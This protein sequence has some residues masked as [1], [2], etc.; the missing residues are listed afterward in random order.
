MTGLYFSY[1]EA[2]CLDCIE[3]SIRRARTTA[4]ISLVWAEGMRAYSSRSF[5]NPVWVNMFSNKYM[6]YAV[7]LA[8]VTLLLALFIP[9][10]NTEVLQL[11]VYEIQGFGWFLAFIGAFTALVLC[12]IYKFFAKRFVGHGDMADFKDDTIDVNGAKDVE[13]DVAAEAEAMKANQA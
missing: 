8:Q 10:L 6:N 4:F 7:L 5:E 1:Y 9:G 11:Y 12:E 13:V 2:G 3:K